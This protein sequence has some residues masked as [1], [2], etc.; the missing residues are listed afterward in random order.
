MGSHLKQHTANLEAIPKSRLSVKIRKT[1][2]GV[3]AI[4]LGLAIEKWLPHID[5][6]VLYVLLIVGG[7]SI[8]GDLVRA[9]TGYATAAIRDLRAA[10]KG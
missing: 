9:A 6:K 10:L 3:G 4:G 2:V 7:Y 5:D 8:A 1:V